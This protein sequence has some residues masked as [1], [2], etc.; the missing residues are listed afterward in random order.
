[1]KKTGLVILA[2]LI[3]AG[4]MHLDEWTRLPVLIQ[5]FSEHRQ[6]HSSYS[7]LAF[8]YRHYVAGQKSESAKDLLRHSQ[9]PYKSAETMHSHF[10]AFILTFYYHPLYLP[11]VSDL[12]FCYT[13]S[14]PLIFAGEFWQ[15][16]RMGE[17]FVFC[18]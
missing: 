3:L 1:M 11:L 18:A 9:L 7:F 8:I 14:V 5:H 2:S 13:Q 16:P 6:Q 4:S 10:T 15:P 17:G 12:R